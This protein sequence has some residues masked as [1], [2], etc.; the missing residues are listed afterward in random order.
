[1][2]LEHGLVICSMFTGIIQHLVPIHSIQKNRGGIQLGITRPKS[3]KTLQKG[4]SIA[5]DGVCL[6]LSSQSAN[7][8]RFDVMSQTTKLTTLASICRGSMVNVERSL[9][10]SDPIGGHVV[11]GHVDAVG[12]VSERIHGPNDDRLTITLLREL[13]KYC[14][15]RG[16]IAINGVSLTIA[17]ISTMNV[18]V[19]LVGYTSKHTNLGLLNR[20]DSVNIEID[21]V[22]RYLERLLANSPK[23]FTSP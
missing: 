20:G 15:A 14:P 3:W 6:T 19:A 17:E 18:T 12:A 1:M 8:L 23:K 2:S 5:V 10:A 9:R 4:E 13:L 11:T 7:T 16:S 21:L 22:A